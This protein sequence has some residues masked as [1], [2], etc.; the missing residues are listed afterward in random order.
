MRSMCLI[1][2]PIYSGEKHH[3]WK[4]SFMYQSIS[5]NNF[6]FFLLVRYIQDQQSSNDIDWLDG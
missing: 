3:L 1:L 6:L 5:R 2:S 4:Y